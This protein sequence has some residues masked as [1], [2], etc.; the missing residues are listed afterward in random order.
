MPCFFF[1]FAVA[2]RLKSG[3]WPPLTGFR[4]HPHWK[5]KT[6]SVGLLWTS[7]QPAAQTSLPDNTQQ[8]SID[9]S[10][11]IRTHNPSKR[12]AARPTP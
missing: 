7:D 1:F 10:G 4:D 3:S 11:G 5:K 2:L 12:A 8:T 6:H 9:A